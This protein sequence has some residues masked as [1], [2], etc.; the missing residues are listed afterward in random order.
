MTSTIPESAF[1]ELLLELTSHS[2]PVNTE[3]NT[4]GMGRSQAFGIV[5]RRMAAPDYS[6]MCWFRP[7]L[8]KLLLDF[9]DKYVTPTGVSWN[10]ITVND[11]YAAQPHKDKG[12]VGNSFLVAFGPYTGGALKIHEGSSA[13]YWNIRH[14]PII[15][16][17]SQVLHSVE[18]FEGRR[19]SLVYYKVKARKG[20]DPSSLPPPK[21]VQ[22]NGEWV[23]YRGE[24]RIDRKIGLPHP[25]K[26]KKSVRR[27]AQEKKSGGGP[28][29]K[30]IKEDV[31]LTW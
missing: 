11:S 10:A 3:R 22:E 13:G 27:V 1:N 21:V 20:F 26:G 7:Y 28:R 6:R 5:N 15:L 8:Y 12:N 30:E 2:L 23:F 31:V 18:A 9:G 4:A 24:E 19:F 25:L 14:N 16:D 17:F 29:V